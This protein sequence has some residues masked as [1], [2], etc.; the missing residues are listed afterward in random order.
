[1]VCPELERQLE[2]LRGSGY[3]RHPVSPQ[4]PRLK[5]YNCIAFAAGDKSRRW[6]PHP[7]KFAFYGPEHLPREV[8]G[9]ETLPN[10]INAFAFLGYSCCQHGTLEKGTEK[11][12]IFLK[13]GHPTHAA[14]QLEN[15]LWTSKCGNSEDIHHKTLEAVEGR[16]YGKAHTF[17]HRPRD[18]NQS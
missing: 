5:G 12:V 18:R 13:N 2:N 11:V 7:N 14:R 17:L 16:V 6:W 9:A 3:D 1:M 8:P 10:F 4:T 15:G